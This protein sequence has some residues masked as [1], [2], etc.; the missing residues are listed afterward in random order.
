MKIAKRSY[1]VWIIIAFVLPISTWAMVRNVPAQYS[2]IQA[3]INAAVNGDTVL[4]A[5]GHY[6]ERINFLGKAI[7]VASEYLFEKDSSHILNTIIDADTSILGV[8]DTGSVVRFVTGENST[9]IIYGFTIQKGINQGGLL[10]ANSEASI[11]CCRFVDNSIGILVS[12]SYPHIDSCVFDSGQDVMCCGLGNYLSLRNSTLNNADVGNWLS[13]NIYNC[14]FYNSDLG[15]SYYGITMTADTLLNSNIW[16]VDGGSINDCCFKQS[17]LYAVNDN[18]NIN[19]SYI[20]NG[21]NAGGSAGCI[22]TIKKSLLKGDIGNLSRQPYMVAIDS[23]TLVN[24]RIY[25]QA[26]FNNR[27]TINNSLITTQNDPYITFVNVYGNPQVHISC[28][29]FYGCVDS[30]WIS[31]TPISL[32]TNHIYFQNPLFCDTASGNY[33]LLN[34]SVCLPSNNGCSTLIGLYGQ[35]CELALNPFSLLSP[36]SQSIHLVVP[37]FLWSRSVDSY[38]GNQ[39][40]YRFYL[41]DNPEFSSPE[42]SEVLLDTSYIYTGSLNPSTLYYWKVLAFYPQAPSIWSQDIFSFYLDGYPSLPTITSP[43]NGAFIDSLTYFTW[44][45][46]TDPDSFDTVHYTVQIDDDSLFGSP[47]VNDSSVIDSTLLQDSITVKIPRLVGFQ[48]LL[49]DHRYYWRVRANDNYGLSSDWSDSTRC[50]V[51]K[52]II[53]K[54]FSL[55]APDSGSIVNTSVPSFVWH[56][57]RYEASPDTVFYSLYWGTDSTLTNPDSIIELIDTA[58]TMPESLQRSHEYYWQVKTYD[59][60]GNSKL[61]N[62]RFSFY[63]DGYHITATTGPNGHITPSGDISVNYGASQSFIITPDTNYHIRDVS[64]DSS[65]IGPQT[66]FTFENVI[67]N[68]TIS[69]SFAIN[70]YTITATA[71]PNGSITP[72]GAVAV[73]HGGNQSFAIV[74]N[75]GYHILDVVVDSVSRGPLAEYVFSNVTTNHTISATFAINVYTITASAAPN[76]MISPS[77]VINI[78]Y[79]SDTTFTMT[80]N[81]GYHV[82]DVLVDGN[83]AGPVT[84]YTFTNVRQ[85]HSI[86]VSFGIDVFMI[87]AT[88]GQNG[89]ISPSGVVTIK[90]GADTTFTITPDSN[91]VIDNVLVDGSSVGNDPTYTF[92]NVVTNHL[93]TANFMSSCSY[94]AGDISGDNQRLG[95]DVTYGVRYF[96]G[97][98]TAP[99]DSCYMDSTGSYLYV[100]GDCNGNCEFR[101]SDITRLVAYFKGNAQLNYCH[102]FPTELPILRQVGQ[103]NPTNTEK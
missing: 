18:L 95:G 72:A 36:S 44:I 53:L 100:A 89:S 52:P 90:Y 66:T 33:N 47:E 46:S 92:M 4:V 83:L 42:S 54:E 68:H 86:S 69:A 59:R 39:A 21:I 1:L 14:K 64:V 23:S 6:Y 5:D 84:S 7:T 27:V 55:I 62:E 17:T 10:S 98:G 51:F 67:A 61:S 74:P 38:F 2:T 28:S 94:L 103:N 77:G 37:S 81:L 91:Y 88:A 80:P 79:G 85:N 13:K 3:G 71:G 50:F 20:D 35:G 25:M 40:S 34:T 22:V 31:G 32:D 99:K 49:P 78:N 9:S 97:I 70:T 29:N 96:K 41:D 45:R 101:G 76:G 43:P 12:A 93:I 73:N 26:Y 102:F 60:W 30:N 82:L 48:N 57:A 8:S 56:S 75:T 24:S 11:K 63:I 19:S 65:S 87:I 58:F 15:S 16:I